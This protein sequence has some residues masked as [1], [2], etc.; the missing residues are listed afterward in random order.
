VGGKKVVMIVMHSVVS[1]PSLCFFITSLFSC[2]SY[3]ISLQYSSFGSVEDKD[4]YKKILKVELTEVV[5]PQ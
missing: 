1:F 3:F 2:I 5:A 4:A